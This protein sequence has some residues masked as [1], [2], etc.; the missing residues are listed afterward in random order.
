MVLTTHMHNPYV[1]P[2][3]PMLNIS[4]EPG[5]HC[6]GGKISSILIRVDKAMHVKVVTEAT[7]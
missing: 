4:R 1:S 7:Q 5:H 3:L 6:R 2:R